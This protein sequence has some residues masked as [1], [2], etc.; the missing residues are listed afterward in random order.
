MSKT[1]A[2]KIA[3]KAALGAELR[4]DFIRT[5]GLSRSARRQAALHND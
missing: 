2:R 5:R 3:A 4:T 1:T